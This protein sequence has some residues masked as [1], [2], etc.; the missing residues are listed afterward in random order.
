MYLFAP[1]ISALR[2][3][4]ERDAATDA[5]GQERKRAALVAEGQKLI[6]GLK[7]LE[8]LANGE[9]AKLA[10]LKDQWKLVLEDPGARDKARAVWA[11]VRAGGG[12]LRTPYGVLVGSAEGVRTALTDESTCSVREYYRRMSVSVG[13]LYLGMDRCPVHKQAA[14]TPSDAAYEAAVCRDSWRRQH[15]RPGIEEATRSFIA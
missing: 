10:E 12:A 14:R 9:P 8:V 7:A 6:R 3:L 13:P 11:A 2:A 4:G 5:A 15:V 1:S